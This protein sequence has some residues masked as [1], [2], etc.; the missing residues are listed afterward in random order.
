M[1]CSQTTALGSIVNEL[2][3]LL[4]RTGNSAL[5]SLNKGSCIHD[6]AVFGTVFR[7]HTRFH[8]W[9]MPGDRG[10]HACVRVQRRQ[11]SDEH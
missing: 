11:C 2:V 3:S 7:L 6:C 4:Q 9:T 10:C 8:V 5:V 1:C